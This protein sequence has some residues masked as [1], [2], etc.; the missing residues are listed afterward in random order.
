MSQLKM[1]EYTCHRR[2]EALEIETFQRQDGDKASIY[3]IP[4][5]KS[6]GEIKIHISLYHQCKPQKGDFYVV[7]GGR[8]TFISANQF[9]AEYS[10]VSS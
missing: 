7:T 3:L 4:K 5:D 10:R 2:I 6:Y 1:P 9:K 8:R